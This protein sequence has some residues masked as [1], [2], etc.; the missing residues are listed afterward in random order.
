MIFGIANPS[1]HNQAT[2]QAIADHNQV[3]HFTSHGFSF[4][5]AV[6]SAMI[7]LRDAHNS[8]IAGLNALQISS[9]KSPISFLTWL[10]SQ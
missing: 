3:I 5:R 2:N 9:R 10:I 8:S 6:I 4:I 1:V 7:G